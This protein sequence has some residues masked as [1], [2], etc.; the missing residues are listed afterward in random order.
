MTILDVNIAFV[1]GWNGTRVCVYRFTIHSL[2][3]QRQP[4][5]CNNNGNFIVY[6][7][8]VKTSSCL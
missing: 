5:H 4:C 2:P 1:G 6:W 8:K 7:S 3:K